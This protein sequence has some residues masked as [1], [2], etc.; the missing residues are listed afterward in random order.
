MSHP[1]RKSKELS[2]DYNTDKE[3]STTDPSMSIIPS[4]GTT[5]FIGGDYHYAHLLA[6]SGKLGFMNVLGE[7]FNPTEYAHEGYSEAVPGIMT[8][9]IVPTIGRSED[10]NSGA[11]LAA[12]DTY[13]GIR[14]NNMGTIPY[15]PAD[16]MLYMLAIDSIIFILS[17]IRRAFRIARQFKWKNRYIP[18][19]ILES[20][21]INSSQMRANFGD[22]IARY[23]MIVTKA[24]RLVYL[25]DFPLLADH[26][27]LF[28]EI[29]KDGEDER[30][31]FYV[32]RPK[33]YYVMTM[34]PENPKQI[35]KWTDIANYVPVHLS[36]WLDRVETMINNI[37]YVSMYSN[38]AGQI[39][40]SFGPNVAHLPLSGDLEPLEPIYNSDFGWVLQ[41]C[42]I[43][44][45]V[46]NLD[47]YESLDV[48]NNL[49][50]IIC[51]P[52]YVSAIAPVYNTTI[53]TSHNSLSA[54]EVFQVTRW[55]ATRAL[56]TQEYILQELVTGTE[57]ITSIDVY[58][59]VV[60][61]VGGLTLSRSNMS[62]DLVL[63]ADGDDGVPS[64]LVIEALEMFSRATNF[65]WYPYVNLYYN[66]G[67][68]PPDPTKFIGVIGNIDNYQQ[69]GGGQIA[70]LQDVRQLEAF[71][72]ASITTIT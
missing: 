22:Y 44:S 41:N 30:A 67:N 1:K 36:V 52:S 56:A 48:D 59:Y 49:G 72:M 14:R 46:E 37:S 28:S 45:G 13:V 4:Q 17:F 5:N 39:E 24:Q 61:P 65:K 38:I 47:I 62:H 50:A 11:N 35:L 55:K 43:V 20:M 6:E 42:D 7:P 51:K 19:A 58:F 66:T 10:I 57:I 21:G 33:G 25:R 70:L 26:S 60:N 15:D 29:Y 9:T 18:D 2:S 68:I 8:L 16:V 54:E 23:D 12:K 3:V 34:L 31:Q 63:A 71:Y 64:D 40:K 53:F 69:I 27:M 32:T